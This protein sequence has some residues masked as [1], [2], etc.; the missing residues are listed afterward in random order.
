MSRRV[1]TDGRRS[2]KNRVR[3]RQR[4]LPQALPGIRPNPGPGT[5][6]QNANPEAPR[7]AEPHPSQRAAG[8]SV[9]CVTRILGA[10][11]PLEVQEEGARPGHGKRGRLG[12]P[13]LVNQQL[14]PT[15]TPHPQETWQVEAGT[16]ARGPQTTSCTPALT[17]A[18]R[19]QSL[20]APRRLPGPERERGS[21]QPGEP[22]SP[23]LGD[24]LPESFCS[25][26]HCQHPAPMHKPPRPPDLLACREELWWSYL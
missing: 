22:R 25:L 8:A 4:L 6:Q 10:G 1:S 21:G 13:P 9:P 2:R 18:H 7:S 24:L 16:V 20:P 11:K 23:P 26:A 5:R 15:A 17:S 19:P 12:E 3:L 14:A